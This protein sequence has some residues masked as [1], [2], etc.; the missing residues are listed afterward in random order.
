[1]NLAAA[2]IFDEIAPLQT[3]TWL[4]LVTGAGYAANDEIYDSGAT[5]QN[6]PLPNP[7]P[8]AGEGAN[9]AR[10]AD[11]TLEDANG[12]RTALTDPDN[13]VTRYGFDELNRV[14]T[15][16]NTGGT[17]TYA[18]D[19]SSLKTKVS[20]PNSTTAATTYD[21]ARRILTLVN[22]QGSAPVS[23]FSYSYDANGNRTEQVENVTGTDELTTYAFDDNDRLTTVNYP[24]KQ[25][26]YTYD[27]NANRTGETTTAGG[28]ITLNKAYTYNTRN[29]LTKVAD[30]I[31]PAND[32]RGYVLRRLIRRAFRNGRSLP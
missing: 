23:S 24:D 26:S 18:Y 6:L 9:V 2:Y 17:T 4:R 1:M 29:Q 25:T 31:T 13:K 10:C 3:A 21:R 15:V 5:Q 7:L 27:G 20:Y 32:G 30:S 11:Q 14:S 16:S 8:Q 19:R 22:L 12:N 28:S